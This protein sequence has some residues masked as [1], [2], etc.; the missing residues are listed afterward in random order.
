M[1][2]SVLL[3]AEIIAKVYYAALNAA[4]RSSV[5]R[6]LCDQIL[7]DEARHVEFQS[8]QLGKLQARRGVLSRAIVNTLR[9]ILFRGTCFV[10]WVFHR[11]ALESGKLTFR[12]FWSACRH[13]MGQSMRV[14]AEVRD[15]LRFRI[16]VLRSTRVGLVRSSQ[17]LL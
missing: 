8:E 14:T 11:R 2:I 15:A 3:T 5:L 16:Q 1:A 13:E 10:V 9:R 4:T 6:T 17:D 12:G 7:S